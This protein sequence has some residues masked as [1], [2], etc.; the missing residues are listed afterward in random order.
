VR[1][2][3]GVK[4]REG[5]GPRR[6]RRTICLNDPVVG[7]ENLAAF[8]PATNVV[9]VEA[10]VVGFGQRIQI[11]VSDVM[12]VVDGKASYGGHGSAEILV[13]DMVDSDG[14]A[15]ADIAGWLVLPHPRPQP[16]ALS[17]PPAGTTPIANQ[18]PGWL[19]FFPPTSLFSLDPS[20]VA[21]FAPHPFPFLSFSFLHHGRSL[22]SLLALRFLHL[23]L[24]V[25]FAI[26]HPRQ[27]RSS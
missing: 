10:E 13:V 4:A 26:G 2:V 25:P 17:S 8:R 23:D 11:A 3:D 7:L 21:I 12:E 24:S 15:G 5:L 16:P 14:Q 22:G 19:H 20:H 9:G 6:R 1:L 18:S 27:V